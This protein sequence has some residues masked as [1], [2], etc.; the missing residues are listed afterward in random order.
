MVNTDLKFVAN[1]HECDLYSSFAAMLKNNTQF[2][3]VL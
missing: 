2:F 3:D 1:E